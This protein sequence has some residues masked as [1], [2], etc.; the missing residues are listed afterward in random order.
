[1][2][3]AD[4]PEEAAEDGEAEPAASAWLRPVLGR[5]GAAVHG[6]FSF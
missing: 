1:M 2:L 6:G 4:D 5:H 3:M